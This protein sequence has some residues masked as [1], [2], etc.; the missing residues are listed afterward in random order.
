MKKVTSILLY[1]FLLIFLSCENVNDTEKE[2]K[3][4]NPGEIALEKIRQLGFRTDTYHK[5]NLRGEDYLI[6]EK[7]IM[8]NISKLVNGRDK[9][10]SVTTD[11]LSIS[12]VSSI[13]WALGSFIGG[14][15]LTAI[16]NAEAEWTGINSCYINISPETVDLDSA[17]IIIS[18]FDFVAA[19]GP[20]Y[21]FVIAIGEFPLNGEPGVNIT[22]NSGFIGA[23]TADEETF[24]MVH[25]LGHNIGFRHTN[26]FDR[27]GNGYTGTFGDG[28]DAD[29]EGW[30]AA[31][32]G[33]AAHILGTPWEYDA[34]SV[35]NAFV[36]P[37]TGFS[38]KDEAAAR[39]LYFRHGAINIVTID[40]IPVGTV[41]NPLTIDLTHTNLIGGPFTYRWWT[42]KNNPVDATDA[43]WV[44]RG[45][46]GLSTTITPG[47]ILDYELGVIVKNA[48]GDVIS[49]AKGKHIIVN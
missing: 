27:N 16:A 35:M 1:S 3:T 15:W 43:R 26:W 17:D 4:D 18:E 14:N 46:R 48:V 12:E 28:T 31:G 44:F 32:F 36:A 5:I 13:T 30:N 25:E 24:T 10:W 23:L 45:R 8:F 7:D 41:G 9:Q 11:V 49:I 40:P 33:N 34:T 37:W 38:V 39:G 21:N 20:L 47:M 29:D 22:I 6:I 19:Y 2:I 42:R